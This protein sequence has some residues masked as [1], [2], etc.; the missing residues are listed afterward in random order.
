M[1]P[2]AR[3]EDRFGD[4]VCILRAREGRNWALFHEKCALEWRRKKAKIG[5]A[6]FCAMIRDTEKERKDVELLIIAAETELAFLQGDISHP[7]V[8]CMMRMSVEFA[9]R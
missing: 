3:E 5:Q 7:G 8:R 9:L 1:A 4:I 6:Q 2:C